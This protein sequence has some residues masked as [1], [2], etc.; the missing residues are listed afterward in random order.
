MYSKAP[1]I[2]A[3]CL[4]LSK[5]GAIAEAPFPSGPHPAIPTLDELASDWLPQSQLGHYPSIHNF[6]GALLTNKDLLSVS[7]LVIP[8][9]SQ[10]YHSGTLY[11]NGEV[12]TADEFRWYAYQALRRKRLDDLEIE[13]TTR[14][15]FEDKGVLFRIKL[16]NHS[17]QEQE[18]SLRVDLVGVVS[19]FE[20]GWDWFYRLPTFPKDDRARS[21]S[22]AAFRLMEAYREH[23][24][25]IP[26]DME[27]FIAPLNRQF[28]AELQDQGPVLLVRD[29][30]TA[31]RTAFAFAQAPDEIAAVGNQ[32]H[33]KWKVTLQP[34]EA[35]T[36]DYVM[37]IGD[38]EKSVIASAQKWA[39]E[40][41]VVFQQA[42]DLWQKRFNDAF[43][44]GNEHFS[45]NLPVLDT[46]DE[47]LR[48]VY[49]MGALTLMVLH[50][51]NLPIHDR[52]YLS[53]APRLGATVMFY[54][55]T[56]MWS[57]AFA[58]LDPDTMKQHLR[59][60]LELNIDEYFAQDFYGGTGI[61]FRY[62]ASYVSIFKM[63]YVY[64]KVT[65][66]TAFLQEEINGKTVL[67]TMDDF[68]MNWKKLVREGD[69]LADFG[70]AW[71]LLECVPTYINRVPSLNAASVWM[72]RR[73]AEIREALGEKDQPEQ[74][75]S[76]ADALAQAVLGLYAPGK[77][78]WYSLHRD[79]SRVEMRHCYDFLT[80]SNYFAESIAPKMADEMVAFLERELFTKHWMRAQSLDD[81]AA[82]RSDRADHGPMGAYDGW[83]PRTMDGMCNF[84]QFDKA[85]AFLHRT[86]GATH[87][88]A[89]SQAHELYGP[90]K[91]EY[92]APV[93]IAER[94][95]VCREASCGGSFANAVITS[96]F[97]Y[98][99]EFEGD[100][101][102][103]S[104]ET[105]RGFTGQLHHVRHEDKFYT[106]R[107]TSEGLT[108]HDEPMPPA[109]PKGRSSSDLS[110]PSHTSTK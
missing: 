51:T 77:G 46:P 86:E 101:L 43:T 41:G 94:D 75:R 93:R 105:P 4:F 82:E 85:L 29:R 107:S 1:A 61:G 58:L 16:K 50:R 67:Q 33:A 74:L 2:L 39:Q 17:D 56:S 22:S 110:S 66:D 106:I 96:F 38:Q 73:T 48:R 5:A 52:V 88:G 13:T 71:D 59:G 87:E 8:P 78:Y 108:I 92:D 7:W 21:V 62:S 24:G 6:H 9:F 65:G 26:D 3:A 14:M 10:A 15:L 49:Y 11:V 23:I 35:K 84:G 81:V 60:W 64:L 68:S 99:P 69:T 109:G 91:R 76:E 31:A 45:G 36:L 18:L 25:P 42:K 34:G 102:L 44:P 103:L 100:K 53:G 80:L 28:K 32:G 83:L 57:T 63:L 79:G 20:D 55:D 97:G 40:F 47:K 70:G 98:R 54:W 89:Y 95:S 12:H 90:N 104:P 27:K 72:M 19:K 30:S 37:A